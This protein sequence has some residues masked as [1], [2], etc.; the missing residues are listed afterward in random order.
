[1]NVGPGRILR[2]G[3]RRGPASGLARHRADRAA[4]PLCTM[5]GAPRPV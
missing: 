5:T 4:S 1:V 3:Y 2:L